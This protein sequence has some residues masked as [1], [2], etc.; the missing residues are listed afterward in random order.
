VWG[1]TGTLAGKRQRLSCS[2]ADLGGGAGRKGGWHL[3]AEKEKNW[4]SEIA[5][6]PWSSPRNIDV[7]TGEAKCHEDAR[8]GKL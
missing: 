1:D 7:Q 3:M 4:R 2:R 6:D 8:G 5:W